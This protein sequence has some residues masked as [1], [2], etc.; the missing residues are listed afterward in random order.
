MKIIYKKADCN[1]IDEL[2]KIRMEQL[3]EEG[4]NEDFD[5]RIYLNE[6]YKKHIIDDSFISW[7]AKYNNKII[8]TSGITI[9]HKP[10]YYSNPYGNI[11]IISSMYTNKK[12]R[13]MGIAK[14]L[15]NRIIDEARCN[16]CKVIQ[17][18]ASDMGVFLYEDYGFKKNKNLMYYEL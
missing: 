2:I 6:Y 9:T 5:L 3:E 18:K 14:E 7:V 4:A 15:L 13:R 1:D 17:L 8:A 12:Y 10:P 11:G 16:N